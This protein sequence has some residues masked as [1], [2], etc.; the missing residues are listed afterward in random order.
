MKYLSLWLCV[1]AF[2][3]LTACNERPDSSEAKGDYAADEVIHLKDWKFKTGDDLN[4]AKPDF[5]DSDWTMVTPLRF[6][7]DQGYKGYDG[8]AWYRISFMLPQSMYD[9][10]HLK[11]SFQIVI[12]KIDDTDQLF[13]NGELLGQNNKII[14]ADKS[15]DIGK[16][17]GDPEMYAVERI[18]KFKADDP[19]LKWGQENVIAI[20]VHDHLGFGGLNEAS[21]WVS[22][23]DIKDYF[24]INMYD[25]FFEIKNGTYKK[26]VSL[27]NISPNS[28]YSGK[29]GVEVVRIADN[30]TLFET[31]KEVSINKGQVVDF[32]F[33]FKL[34]KVDE[35]C[36]V[37]YSFTEK[38]SG[39]QFKTKQEVP[40]ILTPPAPATP[41]INGPSVY[42][43][44]PGN[45]FLYRIPASGD[46]P[47]TF[48]VENL[49]DGLSL[50]EKTGIITGK[51][52]TAGDYELTLK[53]NNAKGEDSK[54]FTVK[55]G[56]KI[57]LTPTMGWNSWNV[58]GLSVDADKVRACADVFVS[59]GL[60]NY[61][62]SYVNIDDGWEA[63]KR[64]N[65]SLL[66]GN[67]KFPDM[68]ALADHVHSRGLKLGIYSSPGPL[69]CGGYLGSYQ[70]EAIDAKTWADWGIDYLKH[71]WCSYRQI[72][73]DEES[74]EEL[75]KPYI[76]MRKSL[77]KC[78]RDIVYSLCQYGMGDVWKWGDQVG[79]NLWR[80]TGDIVDTWRSMSTI[81]FGQAGL[82]QYAKPG[83][84]N[85]PDMLVVGWVGWGPNIHPT[86]LTVNEQYTHISLWSLLSSP[87]LLGCD[88][89]KL[90]DFTLSLLTNHEVLAVN[91]D[92]KG[93]Q[94]DVVKKD[95]D[96]NT[97]VWAK[98]LEDGSLAV[99]LFNLHENDQKM[100]IS[101]QELG[102]SGRKTVRDLW[103]QKDLGEFSDQFEADVPTHGVV[104]IKISK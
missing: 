85:D 17:E 11:D 40:Y 99:G 68:K 48:A 57:A 104:L 64:T 76:I 88:L 63:E 59:S 81:G 45:P 75:Q 36:V 72:V 9:N 97:Q 95:E 78:N 35:R 61:G 55:V 87:L 100:G 16:F 2:L 7:E 8:Y 93:I 101:W 89:T 52:A 74:L 90:D 96:K 38:E 18:Y 73:K 41:R 54:I 94:A 56:D 51:I 102:I 70:N 65:D 71:D 34:D 62:W 60:V 42:G 5:D 3:A 24:T 33:E 32:P 67:E 103:R 1:I 47:M 12:G 4:W 14:P 46:R 13:L 15:K 92:T 58:W 80:T 29:I 26:S 86:R 27:K 79:A 21:P 39:K 77:D 83:N 22:M 82:S 37:Y 66:L 19:R 30:S 43:V 98:E 28:D 53:V 91:Q 23:I 69:T 20:R 44:R 84:W 50:D 49:P 31:E 10:A 25:S 6:W